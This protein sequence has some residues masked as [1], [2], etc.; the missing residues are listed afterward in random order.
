MPRL[1]HT[2]PQYRLHRASGQA[3][4]TLG[5]RDHYLGPWRSK[6]SRIAYDRLVSEW[7]ARDRQPTI[8]RDGL[9]IVD[10]IAR[11]IRHAK[12]Y[13][14]K[15][16]RPTGEAD[17]FRYALRPLR[18]LY[19]HALCDEF[20]PAKLKVVRDRMI[21]NGL[22][23][24]VINSRIRR[25]KQVFSW[26][27]AEELVAPHV[28]QGLAH[29][30]GLKRNRSAA[31]ET[32]PVRPVSRECVEATLPHMPP[33]VADMVQV[34]RLCGCRPQEICLMRPREVDRRDKVWLF[35]P[36][37]YKTE[38]HDRTRVIFIGP[39]AQVI[40]KPYLNREADQYCFS[41]AESERRRKQLM[42]ERRVSKVQPSQVD[43]SKRRPQR[44]PHDHYTEKTY[45]SAIH[46]ACDK[47][48][49]ETIGPLTWNQLLTLARS[50]K[51]RKKDMVRKG[52]RNRWKLA[53]HERA[54]FEKRPNYDAVDA[55]IEWFAKLA[56]QRWSPNQLRHAAGTE[57]RA[58]YGLEAAQ[59]VLGHQ[60]AD[61][62]QI[63]AERDLRRA[64]EIIREVG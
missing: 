40:L 21:R 55:E 26:G 12:R 8:E 10:L 35:R 54:L 52:R 2:V 9:E 64:I 60:K 1:V 17:N 27:V 59:L 62:T 38:H 25:I 42:R 5:G 20:G 16:G 43:R 14:V 49:G 61:V 32:A 11:F 44:K 56:P 41:P 31:R 50:G 23:R 24:G 33:I 57:I 19:G 51:V 63:Y 36:A 18:R 13:Y 47:A 15:D 39:K 46:R 48:F 7:L 45:Y 29:V 6:A 34:Q 30:R 53:S 58:K 4:V 37:A 22:S 3:L 28:Y